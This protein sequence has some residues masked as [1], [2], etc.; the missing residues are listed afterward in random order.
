MDWRSILSSLCSCLSCSAASAVGG[1]PSSLILRFSSSSTISQGKS[2]YLRC[3]PLF[4]S[5]KTT[6]LTNQN[7][8]FKG[9]FH[10]VSVLD[11]CNMFLHFFYFFLLVWLEGEVMS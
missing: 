6:C 1:A 4:S 11:N 2:C 8:F 10:D 9:D 7:L 5:F 3:L